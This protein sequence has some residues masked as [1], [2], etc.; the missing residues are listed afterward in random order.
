MRTSNVI[1]DG[2][3]IFE[4]YEA[5]IVKDG[6]RE[7]FQWPTLKAVVGNDWQE[8]DGFEP[9]LSEPRLDSRELS[10]VFGCNGGASKVAEF[11]NFLISKPVMEYSFANIGLTIPLRVVSMPSLQY[12]EKFEVIAVRFA[13]DSPLSGFS[14][15][16]SS[17]LEENR[18]YVI[19]GVPLSAYGVRTLLGTVEGTM[20]RPDVK[21]LLT[22]NN[23]VMDGA[24]YDQNP[25]VNDADNEMSSEDYWT[26]GQTAEGVAGNW[27]RKKAGGSV[28]TRARDITLTCVMVAPTL[29]AFWNNYN[30]LLAA[31][32]SKNPDADDD[33]LA[34]AHDIIIRAIGGE[35]LFY[36]KSQQVL[37]Y[38]IAEGCVWVQ[39]NLTLTLFK[40]L[41]INGGGG[42]SQLFFLL[43]S[44][45]Q[46]FVITEDGKLIPL[47]LD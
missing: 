20:R 27:K 37:D 10:I 1:I 16:P 18:G 26:V 32:S 8:H 47:D 14:G 29:T 23:S 13:C 22:R 12:A 21:P 3:D 35:Y 39:F 19:D 41:A 25:L 17:D 11:Y 6:Y 15:S 42:E 4:T 5:I 38:Y 24:E 36:Y 45:D 2:V 44:E 43:S 40:E 28:T 30:A 7:L 31:L 9:D 46:G 33:T 34:G